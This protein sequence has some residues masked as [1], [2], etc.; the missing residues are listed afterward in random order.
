MESESNREITVCEC[1]HLTN[2]AALMDTS[3]REDNSF[4]KNI[5]TYI[6][7]GLSI[8]S[9]SICVLFLWRKKLFN[10]R[11]NRSGKNEHTLRFLAKQDFFVIN[12]CICLLITN[13]MIIIGMDRKECLV[14]YFYYI[15]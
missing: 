5:F 15:K 14:I 1:N 6:C 2:F 3:G 4:G 10:L 9:L 7:C 13:L 11:L 8:I 12:L